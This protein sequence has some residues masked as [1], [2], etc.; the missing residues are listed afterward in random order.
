MTSFIVYDL[1][2]HNT[3]RERPYVICF[4]RLNELAGRYNR[5]L[6]H[7]EGQKCKKDTIAFDG[8]N[9]VETVLDFCLKLKRVERKD[10]NNK[11]LEYSLQ[12]HAHNGWGFD[13]WIVLKI[14]SCDKRFVN[15]NRNGKGII[16]LKLS[17]GYFETN[18]KQKPQYLHFIC[19]MTQLN[20]SFKKLGKTFKL[21]RELL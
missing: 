10:N 6:T 3:D 17:N 16:E 8:D 1:G 21:Q 19:G 4:Y 11:I 2:T 18:R 20:F 12:L 15:N 13:T 5:D 9:C 14:L 7:D